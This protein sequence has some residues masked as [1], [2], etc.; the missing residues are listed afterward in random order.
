MTKFLL[1]LSLMCFS[2]FSAQL[3]S[4]ENLQHL[5][6]SSEQILDTQL[7]AHFDL[8][9]HPEDSKENIKV[10][11][12]KHLSDSK[13][14]VLTVFLKDLGCHVF[15][16]VSHDIE[17][18]ELFKNN[19]RT[20]QFQSEIIQNNAGEELHVYTDK[21]IKILIKNPDPSLD[22]HQIVWMCK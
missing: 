1:F 10:Y 11:S 20:D 12:N 19:L 18:V 16:I 6:H 14:T 22:A 5:S 15:S 17:Q 8:L 21:K 13:F 3:L 7:S 4:F 2:C 9:H